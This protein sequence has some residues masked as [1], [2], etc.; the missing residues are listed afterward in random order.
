MSET[1]QDVRER[2]AGRPAGAS[3]GRRRLA[4]GIAITLAGGACWGLNGTIV[5]Y[6]LDAYAMDPLWLVCVRE[7]G[8]CWL[9]LATALARDARGLGRALRDPGEVARLLGV[10]VACILFSNVAYVEAV[11]WTNS[12]TATVLQSLGI[13]FV[14][15]WVCLRLRRRPRRRELAG[16]ALAVA[17]TYLL[18]TGGS[19]GALR[20]PAEGLAWGLAGALAAA[21]LAVLPAG[22][23]RRHGS[24]VV[25]G[26]AMLVSGALLAAWVRPW[27]AVP[28]L[29]ATG[30]ALVA[31]CV[32]VGTYGAFALY[33][34]GV[35]EVGSMRAS[36]LGTSEPLVATA[37]SAALL[38]TAFSATDLAGF[39][40]IVAMVY[41]AA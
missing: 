17:G 34:Q 28:A 32:V 1:G 2:A 40:M 20:I 29:D 36:M 37:S 7:L 30:W 38:G 16:V 8:A 33:L 12:A 31:A 5:K 11:A 24:F 22:L 19:P 27:E 35:R 15:A 3:D 14:M 9:F 41:L 26:F 13:L 39:A 6:L 10:S 4:R 25:N 18:A 21:F 23:L